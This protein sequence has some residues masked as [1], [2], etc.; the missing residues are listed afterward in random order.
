[1]KTPHKN[2]IKLIKNRKE[3]KLQDAKFGRMTSF[4]SI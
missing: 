2:L 1:M 4:N 3:K